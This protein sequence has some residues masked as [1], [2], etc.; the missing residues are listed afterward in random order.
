MG[1]QI[2][3]WV[4]GDEDMYKIFTITSNEK[5]IPCRYL[6]KEYNTLNG[7]TVPSDLDP[8]YDVLATKKDTENFT[9]APPDEL[10]INKDVRTDTHDIPSI[11]P[12][13]E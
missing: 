12:I 2:L 10:I 5:W 8:E 4:D 1:F 9:V 6:E 13:L 7:S 3:P 11:I